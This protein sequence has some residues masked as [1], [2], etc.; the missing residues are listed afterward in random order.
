M[1]VIL[2]LD[3]STTATGYSVMEIDSKKLLDYGCIKPKVKG[4][5]KLVYPMK[6]LQVC[7]S[8]S[9]QI[10]ELY[11]NLT[12]SKKYDIKFIVIEEINRHKNRLSGKT[13]DGLHAI[14]WY[15]LDLLCSQIYYMDS[16]GNSGWRTRLRLRYSEAD[17]EFNKDAKKTNKR[18]LKGTPKINPITKKHLA[19]RFVNKVYNTNFDVDLRK[20]DADI[21][22][23]IGLGYAFLRYV[24]P[25]IVVV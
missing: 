3:L 9:E 20:T 22:D 4:I 5:S 16:D 11:N 24:H 6:Q 25:S 17:R 7:I 23:S 12:Q 21:C 15:H 13:L 19:A 2:N 1:E 10:L 8:I 14:L 18:L